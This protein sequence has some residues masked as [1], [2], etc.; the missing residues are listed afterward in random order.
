MLNVRQTKHLERILHTSEADLCRTLDD[1]ND[2]ISELELIDPAKP[3][4]VREVISVGGEIRRLQEAFYRNLLLPKLATSPYSHG[5]IRGR[6]ILSNVRVHSDARFVF[7][8]DISNF[9]PSI[10]HKRVFN[11][12]LNQL[13]CSPTVARYS[14][15]LCTF[16]NHLAL[17]LVTSPILADQSLRPVDSRIAAACKKMHLTY[18]RFVDDVTISGSYD[19]ETSGIRS[20]VVEILSENGFTAKPSKFEFGTIAE[21][22]ITSL[23]IVDGRIDVRREYFA[24][25]ERQLDDAWNL[26]RDDHFDGPFFTQQ[27]LRGRTQFV[28]WITPARRGRLEKRWKRIDWN[29][30]QRIARERGLVAEK[31]VLRRKDRAPTDHSLNGV[32]RLDGDS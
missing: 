31:K 19:L 16:N 23:R 8:A 27:Q 9:Y 2:C 29:A 4:K 14:T 15:Q 7:K 26:G 1:K 17:G 13:D 3:D 20:A 5:G 18:S 22:S 28:I 32:S 6:S 12:F 30:V 10:H 25:L 21:V 24:E 11:L